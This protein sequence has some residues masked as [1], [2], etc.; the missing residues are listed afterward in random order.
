M[1]IELEHK[2]LQSQRLREKGLFQNQTPEKHGLIKILLSPRQPPPTQTPG[3]NN[4]A[5]P[6]DSC[7]ELLGEVLAPPGRYGSLCYCRPS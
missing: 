3:K 4:K 2:K 6:K 7:N 1:N 5:V